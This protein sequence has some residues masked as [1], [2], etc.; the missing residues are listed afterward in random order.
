MPS[1]TLLYS[2]VFHLSGWSLLFDT[3]LIYSGAHGAGLFLK[4]AHCPIFTSVIHLLFLNPLIF[5]ILAEQ[6]CVCLCSKQWT[7]SLFVLLE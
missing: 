6:K 1:N 2:C 4:A 5:I 3:F 7:F